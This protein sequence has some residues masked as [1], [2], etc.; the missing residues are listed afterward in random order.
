M[1]H[2]SEELKEKLITCLESNLRYQFPNPQG[3]D[4]HCAYCGGV[5][6]GSQWNPIQHEKDCEGTLLIAELKKI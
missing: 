2:I 3:S 5:P 1:T 6:I 4:Y